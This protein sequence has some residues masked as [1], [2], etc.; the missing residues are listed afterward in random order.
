MNQQYTQSTDVTVMLKTKNLYF[1][2]LQIQLD[3]MLH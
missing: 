1:D 3:L 2:L